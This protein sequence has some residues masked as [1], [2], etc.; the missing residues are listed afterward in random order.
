MPI[1][2]IILQRRH[3][4][5]GRIRLGQKGAK[6]QPQKLD[7]FRF[8]S[9]SAD[10]IA[11]VA[12]QYGGEAKP[13]QNGTL[14]E[15]EVITDATSIPVF[16]VRGGFSQWLETWTGGG[17][18][19]RCDGIRDVISDTACRDD[20]PNHANA[21]PTTRLSVMLTDL[22]T[23]GVWRLESHGWNAAAE[24]PTMAELAQMVGDLVPARLYLQERKALRDGRTSR[25]VVPGIDLEVSKA[26]LA[27]IAA[28][29]AGNAPQIEGPASGMRP[30]AEIAAGPAFDE[31]DA[32]DALG[33][34]TTVDEVSALWR[35][36]GSHGMLSDE[37]KARLKARAE[38]L[39]PKTPPSSPAPQGSVGDEEPV[40]A[41]V[42][43]DDPLAADAAWGRLVHVAGSKGIATADLMAL[44][45][46]FSGG[47]GT[48]QGTAA[49]FDEL[50]AQI[51]RRS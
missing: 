45:S 13:W 2:P 1:D 19:H 10:L 33:D 15:H 37:W 24:L 46:E 7:R 39:D 28:G 50:A 41:E 36:L 17:C 8:T 14:A 30:A 47:K 11:A 48:E 44:W 43:E 32:T 51:A 49:D 3:A 38:E 31:D 12:A 35:R 34:A 6:G 29:V 20:D 21:K 40:D 27:E 25:F 22:D 26:R 42:V 18:V 9:A 23:L 4:E 16:V 5:V